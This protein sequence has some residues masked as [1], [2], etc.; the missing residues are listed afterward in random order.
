MSS[1]LCYNS[2]TYHLNWLCL[3]LN[4][5]EETVKHVD[6]HKIVHKTNFVLCQNP[7]R[8]ELWVAPGELDSPE[9]LW[10][11]FLKLP[12]HPHSFADMVHSELGLV[13]AHHIKHLVFGR[14]NPQLL[15]NLVS[16]HRPTVKEPPK[17][18]IHTPEPKHHHSPRLKLCMYWG[19]S[20]YQHSVHCAAQWQTNRQAQPADITPTKPQPG[21]SRC[22]FSWDPSGNC[23]QKNTQPINLHHNL[24][25][26]LYKLN[27]MQR[28]LHDSEVSS[29][30]HAD[31]SFIS[32]T[33]PLWYVLWLSFSAP[34][35]WSELPVAT[36]SLCKCSIHMHGE[37]IT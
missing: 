1:F 30:S 28:H 3:Y 8:Q 29:V 20:L 5:P 17:E 26:W 32:Q 34:L 23:R 36:S 19:S 24:Y 25:V 6:Q 18:G 33:A 21:C 31:L 22:S 7:E 11:L 12:Q 4:V 13:L 15:Q 35:H 2:N 10:L 37:T 27:C 9:H 16:V 14:A